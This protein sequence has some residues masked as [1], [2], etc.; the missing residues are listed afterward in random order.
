MKLQNDTELEEAIISLR[1][2][3]NNTDL[4]DAICTYMTKQGDN[5]EIQKL[6][7]PYLECSEISHKVKNILY[8]YIAKASVFTDSLYKAQF[9]INQIDNIALQDLPPHLQI[10]Y[11]NASAIL[12]LKTEMDYSASLHHFKNALKYCDKDK[13]THSYCA[14]L[15]NIATTYYERQDTTG[16]KYAEEAFIT[17]YQAEDFITAYG[18]SVIAAKLLILAGNIEEAVSYTEK[19]RELSHL[20]KDSL[21]VAQLNIALGD[22][23]FINGQYNKAFGYY[24]QALDIAEDF[25][26]TSIVEVLYKHGSALL[27]DRQYGKAIET[28]KTGISIS[29]KNNS[30]EYLNKLL[31]GL[32]DCYS[33]I[34]DNINTLNYYKAYYSLSDSLSLMQKER[35]FHKLLMNYDKMEYESVLHSNEISM[36]RSQRQIIVIISILLI[37]IILSISLLVMYRNKN[38]LYNQ[39]IEQHDKYRQRTQKLLDAG[40]MA[41]D[42]KK[43]QSAEKDRSLYAKIDKIVTKNKLWR[44]NDLSIDKLAET[45]GSNRSYVSR[46]INNCAGMSFSNY[47]NMKRIEEAT[48]LL[49]GT[50]NDMPL[51]ALADMLGF[52][53]L[54]L[55]S[56]VFQKETGVPPSRFRAYMAVRH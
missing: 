53:S 16:I 54:S 42:N 28:F 46:A 1:T 24:N 38:K 20:T 32:A 47:I 30:I 40:N 49:S 12:A 9:Y 44:Q 22:I 48:E 45:V 5:L 17:S 33:A 14:I 39:L 21:Y 19:I 36:Q 31:M 6:I 51:K 55:F 3:F 18:A 50:E 15:C 7:E 37:T 2:N 43:E 13:N 23:A 29:Y 25:D 34:G 41:A 26:P 11:H 27:A 10:S 35:D 4:W 8:L 52:N 56:K